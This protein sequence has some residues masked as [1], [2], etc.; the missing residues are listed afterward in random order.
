MSGLRK[1]PSASCTDGGGRG[2]LVAEVMIAVL[3]RREAP[4]PWRHVASFQLNAA[5]SI[6][7][8]L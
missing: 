1:A 4:V 6:V 3:A 7:L 2:A 5:F 8:W